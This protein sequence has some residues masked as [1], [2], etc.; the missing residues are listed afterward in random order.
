[1]VIG[2]QGSWTQSCHFAIT[3]LDA[4]TLPKMSVKEACTP[5]SPTVTLTLVVTGGEAAVQCPSFSTVH[6]AAHLWPRGEEKGSHVR[7]GG[8]EQSRDSKYD[9]F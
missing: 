1:M 8:A 2:R 4:L 5:F 3:D 6:C 7:G 9:A